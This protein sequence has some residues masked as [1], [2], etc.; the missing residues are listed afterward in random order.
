LKENI[1][2]LD[3]NA[4]S[5][6][7]PD[8]IDMITQVMEEGGNPSSIHAAGRMAKSRLEQAREQIAKIIHC[9]P[10]MIT[11][12]SGGTE[13]NNIALLASGYAHLITTNTEHDS[14]RFTQERFSGNVTSLKVNQH[15]LVDLTELQKMLGDNAKNTLVS[16]LYANNETGVLQDI[17]SIAKIIHG[18]GA[19]LHI[20]AI[21]ALGKVPLN[22]MDLGCDMMSISAHKIGGPQGAGAIVAFEKL[23]IS[24]LISGGGQEVGRRSGTENVAGIAGFG[25]AVS[26]IPQL[27][28]KMAELKE[29]RDELE[30]TL[31]HHANDVRFIG[32]KAERV[33]NVSMIYM[34]GVVSNTQ[35]MTFDLEN[36]CISSG[37]A[38]SSG[39]V[40][41]SHVIAAME[42]DKA[43]AQSSIRMSLGWSNI[44][45]DVDKFAE[46]WI[47]LY[48]RIHK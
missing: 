44:K 48:D 32:D 29:W 25:K 3:H 13:A 35:V 43:F 11:F 4:T 2:Y 39:K 17:K 46:C 7:H 36:I 1:T 42:N 41:T 12:T 33:P 18:A 38:C 34:P 22:F 21:Q 16:V 6:I 40:A 20:D 9:R 26:M 19:T 5:I 10:Q 45:S 14:V 23:P 8:V 15:G 28:I 31:S 27:L 30:V 24:S 47:K 37:S